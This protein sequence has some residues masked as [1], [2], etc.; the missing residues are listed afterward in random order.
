[1]PKTRIV[2]RDRGCI[3]MIIF[4]TIMDKLFLFIAEK[5]HVSAEPTK[6]NRWLRS[7]G[8]FIIP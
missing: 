4:F 1:M 7:D 5:L 6:L 2:G 3:T 8:C